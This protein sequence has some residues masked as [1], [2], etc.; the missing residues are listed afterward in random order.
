RLSIPMVFEV[1]DLWPHVPIA[2]GELT[3]PLMAFLARRLERSAYR[4]AAHVVA[5][6]PGMRD[7]VL[8]QGV[9]SSRVSVIPN[10]SDLELF[11]VPPQQGEKFRQEHPLIGNRPLVLYCGTLGRV[12]GVGQMVRIAIEMAEIDPEIAFLIVGD[13]RE[14]V[15]IERFAR[16]SGVIGQNLFMLPPIP[17]NEV[18][19]LYAAADLTSSFVI[20][21]KALWDNSAN[22]FFD[23]LAAGKPILIN[24]EGWQ[25]DLLRKTKAGLVVPPLDARQSAEQIQTFL[26]D[27]QRRETAARAAEQLARNRFAREQLFEELH[28][29]LKRVVTS[30][31]VDVTPQVL[32]LVE[33]IDG[34]MSREE[35]QK[36]LGLSDRKHFQ[37]KYIRPALEQGVIEYTIPEKP[38]S[39]A[40]KYRLGRIGQSMKRKS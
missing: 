26:R 2:M 6:S 34:E 37:E 3:N 16:E 18:P 4:N 25:A 12:N 21:N 11:S 1:R 29:I 10:S 5:L 13:G 7:G 40:Q 17:K 39:S 38:K 20:D 23:S 27:P 36:K 9:A 28:H 14:K 19:S 35:L 8:R 31:S 30:G 15:Q 33:A 32:S 22:K 24:H